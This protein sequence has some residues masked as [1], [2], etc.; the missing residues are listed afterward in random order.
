MPTFKTND[1]RA[2]LV[3]ISTRDIARVKDR[4]GFHLPELIEN[5]RA[6]I[7]TL[8][9]EKLAEIILEVVRPQLV[10][11]G[12][13]P[14]QFLESLQYPAV[15]DAIYAVVDSLIGLY[16]RRVRS[17]LRAAVNSQRAAERKDNEN[18]ERILR[19]AFGGQTTK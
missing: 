4:T 1:G 9:E 8:T 13:T 17:R 11:T 18:A 7:G 2:Y 19:E 15:H 12:T 14:E 6:A 10:T 16:P 3:A 5:G